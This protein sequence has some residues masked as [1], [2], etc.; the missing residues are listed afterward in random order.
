MKTIFNRTTIRKYSNREVSDTLLKELLSKAELTPTMGNLQLYSVIATRNSEM[1]QKLAPTHFNQPMV[2]NAA[3]V[4]TFCADFNRTTVWANNRK[5]T[6][7]YDNFLSFLNAATDALLYCQ[8]FTNLAEAE[9]LGTCFLGTTIYNPKQIIDLLK[10]P[11]LVM[12]VATLTIGWPDETPTQPDRLPLESIL[13][14]ETY[15]DYTAE[16]IDQYY[17]VKESLEENKHFV[18]IN[19][20][21]TLAQI[22]T[23]IRYKKSDNEA[24]STGLLETLKQQGFL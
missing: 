13:H 8:T 1:K 20:T 3:V 16:S 15:T 19:K 22:Y 2:E 24:I 7:G 4:L 23:D 5:G 9:G 11:K 10:L 17:K 21:E 6:P 18:E 12:P 14:E